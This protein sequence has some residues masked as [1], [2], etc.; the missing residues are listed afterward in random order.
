MHSDF[1]HPLLVRS[2]YFSV[3]RNADFQIQRLVHLSP[4]MDMDLRS[5]QTLSV[6]VTRGNLMRDKALR[7]HSFARIYYAGKKIVNRGLLLTKKFHFLL[8]YSN[9]TN[10]LYAR[11]TVPLK[12]SY[13]HT[14]THTHVYIYIYIYIFKYCYRSLKV[15]KK[16]LPIVGNFSKV[17]LK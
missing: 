7:I 8:F 17:A 11:A 13:S 6:L 3:A 1:S 10:S 15:K 16:T 12:N 5:R 4:L 2:S 9:E 14:H